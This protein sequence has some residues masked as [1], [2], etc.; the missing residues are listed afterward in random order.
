MKI[1]LQ[2][3]KHTFYVIFTLFCIQIMLQVKIKVAFLI[4]LI[5]APLKN[6]SWPPGPQFE[7]IQ[8]FY[9]FITVTALRLGVMH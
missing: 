1:N 2:S 7:T 5:A 8:H 3:P 6:W 9:T 4:F